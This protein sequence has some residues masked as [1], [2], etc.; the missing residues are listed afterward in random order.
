MEHAE[1]EIEATDLPGPADVMLPSQFFGPMGSGGLHSEQRLML[2]VL[3]DAIN[4]LQGWNRMGSARKRRTFA[5]AAQW[6]LMQGTNYPFSFDNVCDALS[7][8]PE[9]LRQRLRGL[10]R[11]HGATD[12]LGVGILRVRRLSRAQNMT[13]TRVSRRRSN[14]LASWIRD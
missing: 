6:V 7:I 13:A 3:V 9:M 1:H 12:R 10:A 5:D 11:G 14:H 2:A 8:D 4:I